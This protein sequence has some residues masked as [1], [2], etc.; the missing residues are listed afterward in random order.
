MN[1]FLNSIILTAII[2]LITVACVSSQEQNIKPDLNNKNNPKIDIKVNRQFDENGNVIGYDSTYSYSYSDSLNTFLNDSLFQQFQIFP[3]SN[4]NEFINRPFFDIDSLFL[5]D[6]FFRNHPFSNNLHNFNFD[7]NP[8]NEMQK[9]K[10]KIDSL[11]KLNPHLNQPQMP[12]N[13]KPKPNLPQIP[14]HS[15]PHIEKK[16]LPEQQTYDTTNTKII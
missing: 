14:K 1:T 9:M 2:S 3:E 7:F 15:P 4:L 5:K 10:Q 12:Q 13:I 11:Q 8:F 6:P 16:L